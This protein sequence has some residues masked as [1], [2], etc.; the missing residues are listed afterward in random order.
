MNIHING[1]PFKLAENANISDALHLFL[2]KSQQQMSYAV[3]LN[4]EFVGKSQ[5]ALTPIKELDS[6]DILFPIHGG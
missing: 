2:S 5:Y 3:A 1:Q 4:S 6:I